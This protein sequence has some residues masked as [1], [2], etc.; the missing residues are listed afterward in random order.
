MHELATGII[1]KNNQELISEWDFEA[2]KKVNTYGCICYEKNKKCHD[3]DE[4]NCFF[5]Y[6][7]N[8][9]RTVKEGLCKIDSPD[10][11]YIDTSNGKILDCSDCTFPHTRENAIKL[12]ENLFK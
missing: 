11:K 6:C 4:L 1:L 12:L 5:C 3:I 9:D 2:R 10:G 8:Y 7:P